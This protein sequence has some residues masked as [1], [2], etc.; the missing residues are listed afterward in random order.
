MYWKE[1]DSAGIVEQSIHSG[2]GVIR[3]RG[4][5]DDAS[6]LPIKF[7]VWELDPGVSEGSHSHEGDTSLEEIYYFLEGSGTMWIDG[8]DVP[9]AAGD[10]VLVPPGIDHGFRN[11]GDIPLKLVIIWGKPRD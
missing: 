11:V 6:R 10:A 4:F 9:I 2:D 1:K 5:F 7:Q 3:R 8:Q